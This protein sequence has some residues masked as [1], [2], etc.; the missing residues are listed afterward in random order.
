MIC[1]DN[2][3]LA[4]NRCGFQVSEKRKKIWK[5]ELDIL[6]EI[7]TLCKEN[8]LEY[9]LI[10]GGGLGAVRHRGFIPWDDDLD[11]GMRRADL[12][13]FLKIAREKLP[14]HLDVQYG[15]ESETS[16]NGFLRIRDSRTTG[17]LR[18]D[19][20]EK[21]NGGIF[22]EIYPYDDIPNNK[23]LIKLQ[24]SIV[25]WLSTT[26]S[27]RA[28]GVEL[29][30]AKK[31]IVNILKPFSRETIWKWYNHFCQKYN[32]K[33]M[34]YCDLIALPNYAKEGIYM[35]KNEDVM[36][37]EYAEYEYLKARIPCNLDFYLR[38]KYGNYFEFPSPE[39]RGQHHKKIVFYDPD[40]SYKEYAGTEYLKK[41]FEDASS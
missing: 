8:S 28:Y 27:D 5:I 19:A 26:L 25:N 40:K 6:E 29:N 3:L 10:G 1:K 36:K 15:L 35:Y 12:S 33:N 18:A 21:G 9:F 4:E 34:K 37:T 24:H 32:G 31:I 17:I 20:N 2:F 30:I 22:V 39:E 38:K 13:A 14:E 23:I 41:Y 11:I 16:F 7:E